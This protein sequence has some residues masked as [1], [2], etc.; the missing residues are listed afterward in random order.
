VTTVAIIGAGPLG[1]RLALGAARAGYRVFLE[2]VMPGNLHH[3]RESIRLELS[4]GALPSVDFVSTI[5]D[6]VREADLVI[7]CVPDELESKLEIL[8]LL[9]RMAP[10]RTIFATPTVSLSIADLASCTNRPERCIAIAASPADLEAGT[11]P[12][13]VLRTGTA[14]NKE[15]ADLVSG[16][17]VKLGFKPTVERGSV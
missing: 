2:D 9:D 10:P 7:D 11:A 1:H 8:W 17:F 5:E 6:A 3:A 16:F 15:T 4:P 12:G 14:T 13:L